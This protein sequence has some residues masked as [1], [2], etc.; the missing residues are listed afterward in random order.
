M[1]RGAYCTSISVCFATL[2]CLSAIS[3]ARPAIMPGDAGRAVSAREA[4]ELAALDTTKSIRDAA[5]DYLKSP[6]GKEDMELLEKGA[7]IAREYGLEKLLDKLDDRGL[8]G[9]KRWSDAWTI[10]DFY[11]AFDGPS[12]PERWREIGELAADTLLD[13]YYHVPYPA[14]KALIWGLVRMIDS[15]FEIAEERLEKSDE[16]LMEEAIKKYSHRRPV[17][18][19]APEFGCVEL[20]FGKVVSF[21]TGRDARHSTISGYTTP[22]T[23]AAPVVRPAPATRPVAHAPAP[24]PFTT[25]PGTRPPSSTITGPSPVDR[26]PGAGKPPSST[27]SPPRTP[28]PTVSVPPTRTP[29]P[30]VTPSPPRTPSPTIA[31]PAPTAPMVREPAVTSPTA[32]AMREPTST[33]PTTPKVSEPTMTATPPAPIAGMAPGRTPPGSDVSAGPA[34]GGVRINPAPTRSETRD[35]LVKLRRDILRGRESAY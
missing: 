10:I 29:A 7:G 31:A 11:K 13:K 30:A 21:P 9:S 5:S 34:P 25:S 19:A 22:S 32:P 23:P 12:S 16:R 18:R 3:H 2:L 28:A 20:C 17:M 6:A 14:R 27:V 33:T 1:R 4:A 8:L 26:P 24:T 15:A 35:D